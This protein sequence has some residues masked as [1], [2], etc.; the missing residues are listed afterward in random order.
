MTACAVCTREQ[1]EW[2]DA[3]GEGANGGGSP[4]AYALSFMT[5]I[6]RA[7]NF[8]FAEADWDNCSTDQKFAVC[9][10]PRLPH[11]APHRGF[12][13]VVVPLPRPAPLH[14]PACS[15]RCAHPGPHSLLPRPAPVLR[16]FHPPPPSPRTSV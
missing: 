9:C 15:C 3:P 2:L 14:R 11:S 4:R 1:V 6:L 8:N 10:L 13:S 16:D 12:P 5:V 7:L